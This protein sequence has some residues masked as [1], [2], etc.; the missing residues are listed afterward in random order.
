MARVLLWAA[1]PHAASFFAIRSTPAG[2]GSGPASVDLYWSN[3]PSTG[4]RRG[5]AG[6]PARQVF[7]KA[8]TSSGRRLPSSMRFA[9]AGLP[10]SRVCATSSSCGGSIARGSSQTSGIASPS[11]GL[12]RKSRR[13][14]GSRCGFFGIS[15]RRNDP[16]YGFR[17]ISRSLNDSLCGFYHSSPCQPGRICGFFSA[18]AAGFPSQP[19]VFLTQREVRSRAL[20]RGLAGMA[21]RHYDRAEA[22]YEPFPF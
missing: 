12:C 5:C 8:P 11:Y 7:T 9:K 21:Q 14:C 22:Y 20:Q 1:C 2:G 4:C 6:W 19:V 16:L 10:K 15:R 13:F 18:Y 17:E 3:T